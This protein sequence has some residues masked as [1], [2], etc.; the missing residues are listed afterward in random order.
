MIRV[1]G[2]RFWRLIVLYLLVFSVFTFF[3]ILLFHTPLFVNQDVLFYRGLAL[4]VVTVVFVGIILVLLDRFCFRLGLGSVIAA[5][6]VTV[7]LNLC[8]F[9]IFPVTFDRSVTMYLLSTLQEKRV[10]RICSGLPEEKLEQYFID[11][12]VKDN[13]AVRRRISEQSAIG[14]LVESDSC[15]QLTQKGQSFLRMSEVIKKVYLIE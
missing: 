7:S 2:R 5:L 4:M 14:F 9:V 3:F 10:D 15:V 1:K 12:Y 8:F 13:H 11:E 6:L